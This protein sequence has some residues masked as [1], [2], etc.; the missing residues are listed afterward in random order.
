MAKTT[1]KSCGFGITLL[2]DLLTDVVLQIHKLCIED[3]GHVQI[4]AQFDTD[5]SVASTTLQPM[6][7]SK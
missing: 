7:V 4:S 2:T 3:I 6:Q 5:A 1:A